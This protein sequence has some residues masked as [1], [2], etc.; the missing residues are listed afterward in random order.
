MEKFKIVMGKHNGEGTLYSWK[1]KETQQANIGD[2][3]IV[4]NADNF[5]LIEIIA[6]AETAKEY[7][8]QIARHSG[9]IYKNVVYVIPRKL[10]VGEE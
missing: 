9:G 4:E 1:L 5:S 3:A 10:L 7:E 6:I 2:Y 8:K